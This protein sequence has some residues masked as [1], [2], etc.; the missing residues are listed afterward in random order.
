MFYAKLPCKKSKRKAKK[1]KITSTPSGRKRR[2]AD[3]PAANHLMEEPAKCRKVNET[4]KQ[5]FVL[6]KKHPWVTLVVGDLKETLKEQRITKNLGTLCFKPFKNWWTS[7]IPPKGSR[8][9]QLI[10]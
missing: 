3:A 7:L 6:K 5:V 1:W 4:R 8:N 9:C 10:C 2:M